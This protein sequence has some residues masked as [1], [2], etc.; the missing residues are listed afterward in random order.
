MRLTFKTDKIDN[1]VI[2]GVSKVS[3]GVGDGVI[4]GTNELFTGNGW[5]Q[6]YLGEKGYNE[7]IGSNIEF[8]Q[9]DI[10]SV[11]DLGRIKK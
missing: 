4:P 7:Y 9:D 3:G 8:S 1:I 10:I 5:T 6:N 2:P 11:D